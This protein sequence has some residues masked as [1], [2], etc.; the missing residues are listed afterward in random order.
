M[1]SITDKL[2]KA[3]LYTGHNASLLAALMVVGTTLGIAATDLIPTTAVQQG[4]WISLLIK[5]VPS[6]SILGGVVYLFIR[7]LEQRD[8]EVRNL[9]ERTINALNANSN[10]LKDIQI[11][12][13]DDKRRNDNI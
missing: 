12:F 10:A 3:L 5:T 11:Q 2:V 4:D 9:L 1:K 13:R 7:Y 6:L 8:K